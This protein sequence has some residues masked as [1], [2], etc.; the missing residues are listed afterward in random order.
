MKR[1]LFMISSMNIGG[2]EKSLLSLLSVLPKDKYDVTVLMLEKKGDFKTITK[3]GK[4][5]RSSL[6]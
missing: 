2:V 1:V 4:D 3:L 5:R 6:V